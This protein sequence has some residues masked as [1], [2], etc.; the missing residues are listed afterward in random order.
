M[1]RKLDP[2]TL[3]SLSLFSAMMLPF[4]LPKMHERFFF[5]ADMLAFA[6]AYVRRDR[7]SIAIFAAVQI[8]SVL[9][10]FTYFTV[11]PVFAILGGLVNT[12]AMAILIC[13][14]RGI[15]RVGFSTFRA[16]DRDISHEQAY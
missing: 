11:S 8:G 5:L 4:V 6:L 12:V 15:P 16:L 10:Y 1:R 3:L 14:L 2:A 7:R 13:D 9:A